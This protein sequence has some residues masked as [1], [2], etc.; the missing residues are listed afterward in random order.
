MATAAKAPETEV[1]A[2][3]TEIM[4]VGDETPQLVL[5]DPKKFD[6][7]YDRVKA[8]AD[9]LVVDLSTKKGRDE[10]RSVAARVTKSKAMI[11]KARLD[12]TKGW[13]QQ[14]DDVNAA[15][16]EIDARLESLAEEVRKPLTDWEE[17]EKTRVQFCIDTMEGFRTAALVSLDDTAETVRARGMEVYETVID[18]DRFQDLADKAEALKKGAVDT[19]FAALQ[20]L[21]REEKERAELAALRKE[22]EE[23]DAAEAER[24][25]KETA[26]REAREAAETKVRQQRDWARKII[27]YIGEVGL[28]T[29]GGKPYPY[30]ILIRELEEKVTV[31]EDEFG[32]MAGDVE[33]ARVETLARVKAAMEEQNERSRK[34]AAEE[35]AAE[36]TRAAEAAA[37][38]AR[39]DEAAA[40]KRE[41]DAAN[42]RAAEAEL[43]AQAERD[44]ANAAEVERQAAIAAEAAEQKRRE[45]DQAH[46][47]A[48]KSKAKVAL[49]SCGADEETAKKIVVAILA[50]EIPAVRLEF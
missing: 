13:R 27:E 20:R 19:L 24:I 39:Q 23:R 29:I 12:L 33:K 18:P 25:A 17:A 34:E 21:E 3:S 1:L 2:A 38:Q 32:E 26:E 31:S 40:A 9:A 44:R 46:R 49:M 15:G 47:T 50:G 7:F 36:A 11:N 42:A 48:V 10:V 4:F 14:T 5:V 37:E 16:K 30:V 43:A 22:K 8:T 45:E 35:A 28:G 6:A 41:I